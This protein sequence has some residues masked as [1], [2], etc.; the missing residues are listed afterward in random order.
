MNWLLQGEHHSSLYCRVPLASPLLG[1][2]QESLVSGLWSHFSTF[3]PTQTCVTTLTSCLLPLLLL[4][5]TANR[6]LF[7]FHWTANRLL[8]LFHWTANRLLASLHS[9]RPTCAPCPPLGY[10]PAVAIGRAMAETDMYHYEFVRIC[11]R[12]DEASVQLNRVYYWAETCLGAAWG[13]WQGQPWSW[14]PLWDVP[15]Q[16]LFGG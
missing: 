10:I 2:S 5:D 13:F 15:E 7:L 8:F 12:M 9:L 6:L 11:N 14:L 16:I 4:Y 3:P 1:A